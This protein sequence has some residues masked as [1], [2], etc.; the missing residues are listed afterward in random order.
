MKLYFRKLGERGTPIIILHG[1][2]GSSDN[3]LNIGKVLAE[4]HQVFLL[5][6]RNHGQS[7]W[8]D[9][10]DY[11]VMAAD[12]KEFI[13]DHQLQNPILIGHSMGGKV[14]MQFELNYPAL[15]QKVIVV[16]IAPKYYP[17][18]H[19]QILNGLNSLDLKN[20]QSRTEANEHLKRFEEKEG[21]RQFLL[22]N[23]Y[24]N[25]ENEFAFR[26]NLK[27]ITKNIDVVG[28]ELFIK[29][30]SETF[31]YFIKGSDSHYILPEDE[32]YISEIF[33]NFEIIEIAN[34]GHWV[35]ADQPEAFV[36]AVQQIL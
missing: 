30:P 6:Q 25:S 22:K 19:T 23:L 17:V 12:L 15:A 35:Q 20:L 4:T 9:E 7:P 34:A 10:F 26:I 8:S 13:E 24:R 29:N 11:M 1:I 21:V 2:F 28:H 3:W 31:T 18:H 33:P 27:V 36:K 14:V 5:D 16:D 32:R